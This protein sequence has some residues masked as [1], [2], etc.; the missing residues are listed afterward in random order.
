MSDVIDVPRGLSRLDDV[1]D[2]RAPHISVNRPAGNSGAKILAKSVRLHLPPR[3]GNRAQR[4]RQN[5]YAW[6]WGLVSR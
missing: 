6:I 3:G 5:L 2:G 1:V 4:A